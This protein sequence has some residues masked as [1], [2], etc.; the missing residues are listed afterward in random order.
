MCVVYMKKQVWKSLEKF[1]D[2]DMAPPNN[3]N[4][5]SNN[6]N[7]RILKNMFLI[8]WSVKEER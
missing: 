1:G 2:L 4:S 6:N 8:D 3:D 5:S 7:K